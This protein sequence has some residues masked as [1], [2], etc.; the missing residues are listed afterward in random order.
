VHPPSTAL[1]S[2]SGPGQ[3]W[4]VNVPC[5]TPDF[6]KARTRCCSRSGAHRRAGLHPLCQPTS[7]DNRVEPSRE[8]RSRL[9]ATGSID[10]RC[11]EAGTSLLPPRCRSAAR[12]MGKQS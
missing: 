2:G 8:R 7:P 11:G 1:N 12:G 9:P 5:T 10:T 6:E 3:G 4:N